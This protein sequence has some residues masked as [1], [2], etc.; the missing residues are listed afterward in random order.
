MKIAYI[1]PEIPGLSSTFVY[2]EIFALEDMGAEIL[3]YTIHSNIEN[4][5]TNE[6]K[7][8]KDKTQKLYGQ[9]PLTLLK[10]NLSSL[11]NHP[12][13]YVTTLAKAI[14]DSC[15]YLSKPKIAIGILYRFTVGAALANDIHNKNVDHIHVHFAHFP[16]DIAMYSSSISA[17]PFSITAHA[18]DIFSNF[19]LLKQ[20]VHRANFIATISD[21]NK[22]Y[23]SDKGCDTRKINIIRCG[24]IKADYTAPR[25][26]EVTP[27]PIKLGFMGRIVEKKGLETLIKACAILREKHTSFTLEVVGNGPL[28]DKLIQLTKTLNLI[29]NI[30]FHGS[31]DNDKAI[32]W[33]KTLD[34][35][36]LPCV[37]D[38]QGDIDGIPVALMEA[39]MCKVPV[40]S[41]RISGIPEL[42]IDKKTGL[43]AQPGSSKELAE[44]I[45]I[46]ANSKELRN[47]L[48]NN[49]Y[50]H[51]TS[52][53]NIANNVE[54][55][56]CLFRQ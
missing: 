27:T 30:T 4:P 44:K 38:K 40:I 48:T 10:K 6:L 18:N 32:P 47:T 16:A 2:N 54:K 5:A 33:I 29:E 3:P 41:T 51:V 42:I 39:M 31:L 20:K 14:T 12:V 34:M 55:L 43:L 53:F 22:Q 56:Y 45:L 49:A 26:T 9:S 35:F 37:K 13:K 28:L 11:L 46:L 1:A 17:I 52:E 36:I 7:Q 21:Y 19:W 23:L 50:A 24:A 8:L 15:C 25:T